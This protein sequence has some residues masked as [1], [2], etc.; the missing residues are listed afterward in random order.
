M[1][2]TIYGANYQDAGTFVAQREYV[3]RYILPADRLP[4]P[5]KR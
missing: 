5:V 2:V 1:V 3:P 4:W